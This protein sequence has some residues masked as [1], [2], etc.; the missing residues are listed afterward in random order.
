MKVEYDRDVDAIYIQI[1]SEPVVESEEVAP[2]I[3]I[4]FTSDNKVA[5]IE[6]LNASKRIEIMES[7]KSLLELN[8]PSSLS[9]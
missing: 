9:V 1:L 8:T 4:D 3:I 2:D 5:G 6:I 7:I